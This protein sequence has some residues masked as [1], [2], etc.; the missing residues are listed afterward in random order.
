MPYWTNPEDALPLM[1]RDRL[2]DLLEADT[3]LLARWVELGETEALVIRPLPASAVAAN[4][5]RLSLHWEWRL[6]ET[7][8]W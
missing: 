6:G 4:E 7:S 3:E 8:L 2:R 5:W 1:I